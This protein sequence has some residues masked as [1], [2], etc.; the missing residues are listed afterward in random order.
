MPI[1]IA[2]PEAAVAATPYL[3]GFTPRDSVVL[4]LLDD[5]VLQ[6]AVRVD[7]PPRADPSWVTSVLQGMPDEVPPQVLMLAFADEAPG[8]WAAAVAGWLCDV[9]APLTE[10]VGLVVVADGQMR[11]VLGDPVRDSADDW[12]VG[13][14]LEA[15]RDHPVVAECVANGLSHLP[16]REALRSMLE[17]VRDEMAESVRAL[18]E[19]ATPGDEA[20]HA[21][22]LEA[23]SVQILSG[24]ERLSAESVARVA[25]ACNDWRARDP[26]FAELL[27]R[28]YRG[29]VALS[30]VRTRLTYCLT[31]TPAAHVGGVAASLALLS[32]SDGDGAAA[33]CAAQHASSVD[34]GNTL[35]PLVMAALERGL[36][37]QTWAEVTCDIPRDV[38]RGRSRRSA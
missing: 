31:H 22:A 23:W 18:L 16:D 2:S 19:G 24:V 29:D 36:P 8:D 10:L 30:A 9:L 3:L 33:M 25:R 6:V 28:S 11:S 21:Q 37:P 32:W 26:M 20:A 7:I 17:P 35:A 27:D 15:L 14:R 13:C 1:S 12:A 38:L 4:L 5:R 34:P